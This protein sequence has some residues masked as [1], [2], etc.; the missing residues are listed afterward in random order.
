MD[1]NAPLLEEV[2]RLLAA[3]GRQRA[4]LTL[5]DLIQLVRRGNVALPVDP[6]HLSVLWVLDRCAR[7]R[8][9]RRRRVGGAAAGAPFSFPLPKPQHLPPRLR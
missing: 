9:R 4:Y 3:G 7:R 5:P 2:R 1:R 8:R 6:T